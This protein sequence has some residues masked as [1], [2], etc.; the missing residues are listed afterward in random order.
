MIDLKYMI[1][2]DDNKRE[3]WN[4][5]DDSITSKIKYDGSPNEHYDPK[6]KWTRSFLV[7]MS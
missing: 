7:Q 4:Q 6:K 1:Q 5:N 2:Y 3:V